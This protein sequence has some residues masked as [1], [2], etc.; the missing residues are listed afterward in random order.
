MNNPPIFT[1]SWFTALDDARHVRI[2]ISRGTPRRFP[3]G[4]RKV[5]ALAP[6]PWF[7]SVAPADYLSLFWSEV[8]AEL[9]PHETAARLRALAGGRSPV[10]VCYE[11]PEAIATGSTWCHRH[12]VA[13]WLER[14]LGQP[15]EEIGHPGLDRWGA[16]RRVGIGASAARTISEGALA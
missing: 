14:A 2:G 3:A 5:K 12:I 1:G 10:I 7:N 16:L 11:K 8:L 13:E 15:V 6:G 4:Y 9:D